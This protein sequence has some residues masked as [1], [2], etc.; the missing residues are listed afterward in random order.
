MSIFD[1]QD[2]DTRLKKVTVCNE[3]TMINILISPKTFENDGLKHFHFLKNSTF[4]DYGIPYVSWKKT[5]LNPRNKI[6]PTAKY[7]G[8]HL[9]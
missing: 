4:L 1:F 3:K 2:L 8:G 6:P 7:S 9:I 5:V